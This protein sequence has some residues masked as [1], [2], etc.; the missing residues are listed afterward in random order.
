MSRLRTGTI[1]LL[2]VIISAAAI[3]YTSCTPDDKC[4]V[5]CNNGGT[6]TDNACLCP[7]AYT[8]AHCDQLSFTGSWKGYDNVNAA[9]NYMQTLV[10]APGATDTTV[11]VSFLAGQPAGKTITGIIDANRSTITFY[12]RLISTATA[13][14]DTISGT[15]RLLT[16]T[17][18]TG[19][20]TYDNV[21]D[22]ITYA[23]SGNYTKQ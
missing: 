13:V 10:I 6:C 4:S 3:L 1:S 9:T 16:A 12:K 22:G 21:N 14:P 11:S 23:V 20:Y 5:V 7:P 19:S 8:G 18:A 2:T 17:A 15:I